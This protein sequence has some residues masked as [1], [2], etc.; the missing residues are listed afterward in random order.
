MCNAVTKTLSLALCLFTMAIATSCGGNSEEKR[1]EQ[2]LAEA[3]TALDNNDYNLVKT[4]IDSINSSCPAAIDQRRQAL[5]LATRAKEGLT[6]VKLQQA[7]SLL[8]VLSVRSDS[9]GKLVKFVQNP[10]EGYYVGKNSDPLSFTNSTGLQARMTPNGDFYL[11]SSLHGI[12]IN[13]TAISVGGVDSTP[14]PYDGER[15]DRSF[16]NEV[17]TFMGSECDAIGRTIAEHAGE[18]MILIFKGDKDYRTTLKPAQTQEIANVYNLASCMRAVRVASLEK[19][20][21][22][23]SVDIARSQAARTFVEPDS[24]K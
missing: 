16:G 24:L 21:L 10:I 5:H 19:D 3:Q 9:L 7:D 6:V 17:I 2:L 15:N 4:L 8:A 22:Q 14:V 1:A 18:Q 11:V 12:K 20:R 23:K 13:S